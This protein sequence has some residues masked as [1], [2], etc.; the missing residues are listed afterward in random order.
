MR[1][2]DIS[3]LT[4]FQWCKAFQAFTVENGAPSGATTHL[5]LVPALQR[6][7]K[8][9]RALFVRHLENC[10]CVRSWTNIS[11]ANLKTQTL[12]NMCERLNHGRVSLNGSPFWCFRNVL[13]HSQSSSDFEPRLLVVVF[14]L[15][16]VHAAAPRSG[17]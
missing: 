10:S 2:S 13:S 16:R 6:W 4:A 9:N 5:V 11:I 8:Q 17:L 12:S 14:H 7:S 15:H 3:T 1:S